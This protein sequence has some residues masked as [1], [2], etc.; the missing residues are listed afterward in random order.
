M[1]PVKILLMH[2]LKSFVSQTCPS[3]PSNNR[4]A[5]YCSGWI[6]YK[7]GMWHVNTTTVYTLDTPHR[8]DLLLMQLQNVIAS[9][10]SALCYPANFT[11]PPHTPQTKLDMVSLSSLYILWLA[12][13]IALIFINQI[14]IFFVAWVKLIIPNFGCISLNFIFLTTSTGI[15]GHGMIEWIYQ[16]TVRDQPVQEHWVCLSSSTFYQSL[17]QMYHPQV[18]IVCT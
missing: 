1:P 5:K 8:Q 14:W 2:P 9:F 13:F 11:M 15:S 6:S 12:I 10:N 17:S 3:L 7:Q 16:G 18:L 4:W